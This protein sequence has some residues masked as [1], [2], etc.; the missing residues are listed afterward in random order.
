M[1]EK[2]TGVCWKTGEGSYLCGEEGRDE[3]FVR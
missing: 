1:L 3:Y 2:V